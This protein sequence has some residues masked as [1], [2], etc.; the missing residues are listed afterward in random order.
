MMLRRKDLSYAAF[1]FIFFALILYGCA[2]AQ[3]TQ[4]NVTTE[5]L[6]Q[7]AGFQKWNVNEQTPSRRA[8]LDSIPNGKITTFQ[9]DGATYHAYAD[10]NGKALYVG[11]NAAYQKYVT[12][13]KGRKL[14]ERVTAPDSSQ[15][16]SCFG[17]AQKGG[18]K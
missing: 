10:F 6:L 1:L 4:G 14:C 8:L 9:R 17:E 15:F 3:T 5:Y 12:L 11:D 2:G 13:S 16:W 18:G 7:K